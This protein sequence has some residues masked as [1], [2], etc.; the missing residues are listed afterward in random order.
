MA[1]GN[2]RLAVLARRLSGES[3]VRVAAGEVD[4]SGGNVAG[5]SSGAG[6]RRAG[7]LACAAT[8]FGAAACSEGARPEE[9]V[10]ESAQQLSSASGASGT[11]GTSTTST[12]TS[13][14][15]DVTFRIV[16]P[17]GVTP[18]EVALGAANSL[19]VRDGVALVLSSG[20]GHASASSAGMGGSYLGV[21]ASLQ[22]LWSQGPVDLR[23]DSNIFGNLVTGATASLQP[24]ASIA[25]ARLEHASLTPPHLLTWKVS[26]PLPNSGAVSL[27][28][29]VVRSLEPGNY[30]LLA[31]KSRAHLK[32]HR[33]T[34]RFEDGAVEPDAYLDIDNTAGPVFL[35]FRGSLIFSGV[36]NPSSSL[37]NILFGVGNL[38]NQFSSPWK[39]VLVGNGTASLNSAQNVGHQGAIFADDIVLQPWTRFRHRPLVPASFCDPA[40]PTGSG[41]FCPG[42]PGDSCDAF[43]ACQ[44]GLSCVVGT[45][46]DCTTIGCDGAPCTSGDACAPGLICA[47]GNCRPGCDEHP[48]EPGCV[49]DHCGDGVKDGTETD[50]DCGGDCP[51][52]NPSGGCS[53]DADCDPGLVCGNNN[54]ACYG[55]P[56]SQK[57]CWPAQCADGVEPSE[58]G[59]PDSPCGQ[60]CGCVVPCDCSDSTSACPS[61]E[62][63]GCGLGPLF[64]VDSDDVCVPGGGVCPS[65]DPDECGS[66][67][68]LCGECICTPD[69]SSATRDK[70][71]DGCHGECPHLCPDGEQCCT[72]SLHCALGS[73]C[74]AG[75]TG[76]RGTCRPESCPPFERLAPPLCGSDNAPCSKECPQPNCEGRSCGTD[77]VS[78]A[79]C[80]SCGDGAFCDA[81]GQCAP[82][83]DGDPPI[84]V[85]DGSGGDVPLEDLPK[86]TTSAVGSLKGMFS[87]SDQ[88]TAQYNIPIEVPPGRA[89]LEPALSLHYGGPRASGDVGVGWRIEGLS[90]ITRCPRIQALDG[91]AAPIKNDTSD[92]F[93][94]DGR[95][96]E[97]VGSGEYG[98]DGTEYRTLVDS[99]TK[100]VSYKDSG[101]GQQLPLLG[102]VKRLLRPQQGPDYF[103]VWMKDGRILTYGRTLSS[104]VTT[105]SGA[106]SAWMLNLVE[107][108]ARNNIVIRY[109]NLA[110]LRYWEL[111]DGVPNVV[112]PERIAYTGHAGSA[113]TREVRFSYESRADQRLSFLQGGTPMRVDERLKAVTTY[114]KDAA[115]RTYKLEYDDS[116]G[117]SVVK[118]VRECAGDAAS[119]VC[120]P[121]T[122]FD[123]VV[124]SGFQE[125]F[126]GSDLAKGGE[127]D[128]TG[129]G[130]SDSLTT[131][132][133]QD[134][135]A[136]QPGLTA[137]MLALDVGV[138][139]AGS[140]AGPVGGLAVNVAWLIG[141]GALVSALVPAPKITLE[142]RWE[143]GTNDR[144]ATRSNGTAPALSCLSSP[145]T[146]FLDYDQDGKD[147]VATV[148]CSGA[149]GEEYS[150]GFIRSLGDGGFTY[151]GTVRAPHDGYEAGVARVPAPVMYDVDGDGLQDLVSCLNGFTLEVR[152]RTAPIAPDTT[153]SSFA[154]P[155]S[156]IGPEVLQA[157]QMVRQLVPFCGNSSPTFKPLDMDADG[158][159]ELL[160]FFNT[161]SQAD[162]HW[163][164]DPERDGWYALRFSPL[165]NTPTGTPSIFWE[166]V[167]FPGDGFYEGGKGMQL[168][169][170]N[171]DGLADVWRGTGSPG[172]ARVWLNTGKNS[173]IA[174]AFP[175]PFATTQRDRGYQLHSSA[176]V[177]Y[178]GD[179]IVDLIEHWQRNGG[180]DENT[181]VLN[182][183]LLA[184]LA[185]VHPVV[186][187]QWRSGSALFDHRFTRATDVDG[188]GNVDLI[189]ESKTFYGSGNKNMLLKTVTD[190]LGKFVQVSY[191]AAGTY[192]GDCP[193]AKRWPERCLKRMKGLVSG[194]EEGFRYIAADNV[195]YDVAERHYTYK[196]FN[197]RLNV[198]GHGWL[199]FERRTASE[200]AG[201]DL[202]PIRSV[203]TEFWPAERYR[204]AATTKTLETSAPYL[205]PLAGLPRQVIID[206]MPQGEEPSPLENGLYS[207]RTVIENRWK[208]Q[209]SEDQRPFPVLGATTTWTFSRPAAQAGGDSADNGTLRT[210]CSEGSR[211]DGYG[212]VTFHDASCQVVHD[213]G[214]VESSS[215]TT[216]FNPNPGAWLLGK[217]ELITTYHARSTESQGITRRHSQLQVSDPEYDDLGQLYSLTRDPDGNPFGDSQLGLPPRPAERQ[218]T[219]YHRDFYGNIERIVEDVTTG[220]PERTTI[221]TYDSD[222]IFPTRIR[223]AKDHTTQLEIEPKFGQLKTLVDPNGVAVRH[224]YDDL[225][226]LHETQGP[227]GI[228]VLSYRQQALA[229]LRRVPG[230]PREI[231]PILEVTSETQG[232]AGTFGGAVTRE[233]DP[234]G[235]AVATRSLGFQ[236]AE[237]FSEQAYDDRGRVVTTTAPH[238]SDTAVVPGTHYT[239]DYLN[240]VT[241]EED[242]ESVARTPGDL[243]PPFSVVATRQ[244]LYGSGVSLSSEYERLIASVACPVSPATLCA[245]DVELTIDEEGKQNAIVKDHRG[246]AI[247]NV[248]GWNLTSMDHT[249]GF[250]YG[251][252]NRLTRIRHNTQVMKT[253]AH[254]EYGR[255][256][257]Y[258]D[259]IGTSSYTY[260]GFG[261]LKT[262]IDPKQ[263][264]RKYEHDTLGR[265]EFS[266]DP[267]DLSDN[268][269]WIFDIGPS[270]LGQLTRSGSGGTFVDYSY[271]DSN[272]EHTR[273]LPESITYAVGGTHYTIGLHYD[274]LAR[275]D[276]IDYPD[277]GSGPPISAKYHYD[278]AS[279]ALSAVT[280]IGSTERPIWK[281]DSTYE[282]HLIS[283]ETFG[284]GAVTTTGYDPD[285]RWLTSLRTTLDGSAVQDLTYSHY[286]N[287]QIRERI[288]PE[289]NQEFTYD[290]LGQLASLTTGTTTTEYRYEPLGNITQRGA[291]TVSYVAPYSGFIDQVGQNVYHYDAAGNVNH[292]A[293]PDVP[294]GTQTFQ[295]TAFNLPSIIT[296][297][298]GPD[299]RVTEF[300]YTADGS[301]VVRRDLNLNSS[302]HFVPGLYQRLVTSD[303]SSTLEERFRISANGRPVAEIVRTPSEEKILYFHQDH[304]G[305]PDTISDSTGAVTHQDYDPFGL[306][307]DTTPAPN[308]TLTRT[309][310]TGHQ[311]DNDLALTDMGGRIY[312][313]LAGRFMSPDPIMQAPYWSQG[314][315]RYSYVFND[316]INSTDPSGFATQQNTASNAAAVGTDPAVLAWGGV[317]M[318]A[319]VAQAGALSV[320]LGA[321]AGAGN[322]IATVAM[323]PF[324]GSKGGSYQVPSGSAAAN[325]NGGGANAPVAVAQN[326]PPGP[327]Q[328]LPS[329]AEA[330]ADLGFQ[331]ER[332]VTLKIDCGKTPS[333]PMCSPGA[334]LELMGPVGMVAKPGVGLLSRLF[335][336]LWGSAARSIGPQAAKE[337][338]VAIGAIARA[339]GQA[340]GSKM[341]TIAAKVT[342][343]KL[344]QKE[345]VIA[346]ESA[347]QALP[348]RTQVLT[349]GE[350][351]LVG[352]PVI[353]NAQ[354]VLIVRPD[355][356][357]TLGFADIVADGKNLVV[358]SLRF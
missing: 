187:L 294:G 287:G 157:G 236:G 48:N 241:K 228:S 115:V 64:K 313:P 143:Q 112:R 71:S 78:G 326:R 280:E 106:R 216:V 356:S 184:S 180:Q 239:Y 63:C 35:Y 292:R 159:P 44:S 300:A 259:E 210:E 165:P 87:V 190:G 107:D 268:A 108:R 254:D 304:L 171:G 312:D 231:H 117:A 347:V 336:W 142:T 298:S 70:P 103:K 206:V 183:G 23:N 150:I 86:P 238:L 318:G 133:H 230:S 149:Y 265:L 173:F 67:D 217:P 27:E 56:R 350:N 28:P 131:Q 237:V 232:L 201:I 288:T 303:T 3:S 324:G 37:D 140:F 134:D 261:E 181:A 81:L 334:G 179:G 40:N 284:N 168:A 80:G 207:R 317:A 88:G 172:E 147:D 5:K 253:L 342:A 322:V 59:Q 38:N 309:G 229:S 274:D 218:R 89:G 200:S 325:S 323:N 55:Q 330:R 141:K 281:V 145:A 352:G 52:C 329:A 79:S 203:T 310:F 9:H 355:G 12:S 250:E 31:V 54:G 163:V 45:C 182:N 188:D 174:K 278:P 293:G 191:D 19:Q 315:N 20:T 220:E 339:A 36:T 208:V 91:Y 251:A 279:G 137:A 348:L 72:T 212:N 120:K 101:D 34:Y 100:V 255:L 152:L 129:D 205:Y 302:R 341:E 160:T 95:R 2:G 42:G 267:D 186:D 328:A 62:V 135:V 272:A 248:D 327:M 105:R 8:L 340:G 113:G 215:V 85:P 156:L 111:A 46:N 335:G 234:Y 258:S 114:V 10:G 285:R 153:G 235:R 126:V 273:A 243:E 319:A 146:F 17:K 224:A 116:R 249:M 29:D 291:T 18:G 50:V 47:A 266:F 128:F 177:D 41:P 75:S 97:Q 33:G 226:L 252:F 7:L 76:D 58:C 16:T 354:K 305:T 264:R 199:G 151:T 194:H 130:I 90:Q 125:G 167:Q 196:Y 214:S 314:Q 225:G 213:V 358:K 260:S 277:T 110:A 357:T 222:K 247:R 240:R 301:R 15:R 83:G 349:F 69:C 74:I 24:G 13:S 1:S 118:S 185:P 320:G 109:T 263:R 77:P 94:I 132:V 338:G 198:A 119:N 158:T 333:N 275:I 53:T 51:G 104:L 332:T 11:G 175:H 155:I 73:V 6:L 262:S 306:L 169:D 144:T 204:P 93:C 245:V 39:G 269:Q 276:T 299:V 283:Q 178:N 98:A 60:N 211:V 242:F 202:R 193:E 271:E 257:K 345:A 286:A 270:G 343:E 99:F 282:G 26:F 124:E 166:K 331:D 221:I 192:T 170:V 307:Q 30:G 57:V 209:Q 139:V 43:R 136:A 96:L 102:N 154:D 32:L 127:L 164:Q 82:I 195:T 297:G 138:T 162:S 308:Q 316:P 21:Q 351:Q 61:G 337:L 66:Q 311:Q 121:P 25:G 295:Y 197:A 233:L 189:G 92:R 49:P 227:D 65:N 344:I 68:A 321:L 148:A 256:A 244:Q 176:A 219:T 14:S 289:R 122:V 161:Y 84:T 246:L 353:G 346:V 4:P 22:H 290:A 296:T 223:N 123:Y